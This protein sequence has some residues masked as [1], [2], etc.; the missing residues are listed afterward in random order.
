[1]WSGR[2]WRSQGA[3]LTRSLSKPLGF[4]YTCDGKPLGYHKQGSSLIRFMF[5]KEGSGLYCE[6]RLWRRQSRSPE[7][8]CETDLLHG[9]QA[10]I[11]SAC[12]V[13]QDI[14][15]PCS[16]R[17]RPRRSYKAL[18]KTTVICLLETLFGTCGKGPADKIKCFFFSPGNSG[19]HF[20]K[21]Q[22]NLKVYL[23]WW[24]HPLPVLSIGLL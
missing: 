23:I 4:Y 3:I 7:A 21:N 14:F 15:S 10:G 5:W 18:E 9:G 1:M 2:R 17:K 19:S 13:S 16:Y 11:G 20:W 8:G 24:L 6:R 12:E 22:R